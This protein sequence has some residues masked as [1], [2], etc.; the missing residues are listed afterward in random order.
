MRHTHN[1]LQTH[2]WNH[3]MLLVIALTFKFVCGSEKA[4]DSSHNLIAGEEDSEKPN[5]SSKHVYILK[6]IC[7]KRLRR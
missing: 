5:L 1:R 7:G 2:V 3:S 6:R 4:N